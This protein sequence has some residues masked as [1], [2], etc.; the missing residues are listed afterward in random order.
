LLL[1]GCRNPT[2]PVVVS[3]DPASLSLLVG[4]AV[5]LVASVESTDGNSAI[6]WSSSDEAV[7]AVDADGKV[8]AVG[9]GTATISAT[10]VADPSSAGQCS[11]TVASGELLPGEPRG[12]DF[13]HAAE[14]WYYFNAAIGC[15]YDITLSYSASD[16]ASVSAYREDRSTPYFENLPQGTRAIMSETCERVFVR[17]K[18]ESSGGAFTVRYAV[19]NPVPPATWTFLMYVNGYQLDDACMWN[20]QEMIDGYHSDCGVNVVLLIDKQFT[21]DYGVAGCAFDDTRLFYLTETGL[22]PIA[23]GSRLRDPGETPVDELNMGDADT[24]RR[25]IEFGKTNYPAARAALIVLA[26]GMGV[27]GL[28]QDESTGD[29]LQLGEISAVLDHSHSVDLLGLNCCSM[30]TVETAYQ[31]RSVPGDVSRFQVEVLVA[32]PRFADITGWTYDTLFERIDALRGGEHN[33]EEAILTGGQELIYAPSSMTPLELGGLIVEEQRDG[34]YAAALGDFEL[35]TCF[36]LNYAADVKASTDVFA[37]ALY[38]EADGKA[39]IE[40]IRD[41]HPNV[42]RYYWQYIPDTPLDRATRTRNPYYELRDLGEYSASD[43]RFSA[44]VRTAAADLVAAVDDMIVYSYYGSDTSNTWGLAVFFSNGD[45]LYDGLPMYTY[46]WWY[47][48]LNVTDFVDPPPTERFF[49]ELAWCIDRATDT[50]GTVDNF[51]EL[52]DAWY[53]PE[54][55]GPDGG[56]NG[57]RY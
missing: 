16:G 27:Q 55:N 13:A 49:G 22:H 6:S 5:G 30:G 45:D 2:L 14:K 42:G 24:L 12:G 44:G 8:S 43:P 52:Q 36:D 7:A 51:F 3:V 50:V 47:N 26:H 19:D 53:D 4:E 11:V 38:A 25:F 10:S 32:A 29:C 9:V 48:A 23:G 35:L 34:M 17:V 54:G 37:A 15:T 46:Q 21:A 18:G 31:F 57:Y 1:W 41:N 56:C 20:I 28:S 40:D 33:G 39:I